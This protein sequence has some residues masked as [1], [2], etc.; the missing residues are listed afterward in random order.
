M[1]HDMIC[2]SNVEHD[3]IFDTYDYNE[4]SIANPIAFTILDWGFTVAFAS[5]ITT[6][7]FC[8]YMKTIL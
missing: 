6:M 8:L 1:I 4:T 3:A 2:S 7:A 5:V